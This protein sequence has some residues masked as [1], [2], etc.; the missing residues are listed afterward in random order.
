MGASTAKFVV[1]PSIAS[2]SPT[3]GPV[4]TAVT[5]IGNTFL[6]TTK[7]TFGGVAATSY[8]VINDTKVDALVPS[9]A[10]TGP[11]AV[12]TAAGTATS[13]SKFTVTP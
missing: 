7:V 2:L 8:Q 10:V 9:G 12:T 11:V 1:D 4:G 6:G 3:S 13:T 5:I